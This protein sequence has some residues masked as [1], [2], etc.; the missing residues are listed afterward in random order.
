MVASGD[1]WWW[2]VVMTGGGQLWWWLL[3]VAS[4]DN[5]DW[6][7][8]LVVAV[9]VNGG[10]GGDWY[11]VVRGWFQC[12]NDR[13]F[14]HLIR[15]LS[16][17]LGE[18]TPLPVV[19]AVFGINTNLSHPLWG[20][21]DA[22]IRA[23]SVDNPELTDVL[24]LK[25]AVGQNDYSHACFAHCQD[26][27]PYPNFYRTLVHSPSFFSQILSP[28]FVWARRMNRSKLRF[29]RSLNTIELFF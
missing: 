15:L 10:G 25:P 20:T 13:N 19:K 26:F 28:H 7:R 12:S 16:P 2:L 5:G 29:V 22:E 14:P 3:V 21:A 24:P 4:G 1:W 18:H 9:I 8:W 27:L 11:A 23:L 6:W 17:F